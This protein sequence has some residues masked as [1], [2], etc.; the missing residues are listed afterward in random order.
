MSDDFYTSPQGSPP[1]PPTP[2][3]PPA[4]PPPLEYRP[5]GAEV[6][7]QWWTD[8]QPGQGWMVGCLLAMSAVGAVGGAILG[9]VYL[10]A[11]C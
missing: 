9:L 11:G 10:L 1:P 6:K 2:P 4:P 7:S 8:D 3:A 5:P